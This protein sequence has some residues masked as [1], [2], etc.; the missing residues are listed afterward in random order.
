MPITKTVCASYHNSRTISLSKVKWNGIQNIIIF[1][2]MHHVR[3]M[4]CVSLKDPEKWA[5]LTM[6]P[7]IT[8]LFVQA[9]TIL[10]Q[11]LYQK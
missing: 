6:K 2:I 7:P 9:T 10:E 1:S 8:K 11:F 4:Q 5:E 3:A